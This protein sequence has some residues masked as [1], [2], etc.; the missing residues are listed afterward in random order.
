MTT[1]R[2]TEKQ[3]AIAKRLL[4]S[5]AWEGGHGFRGEAL[6]TWLTMKDVY[7]RF[8]LKVAGGENPRAAW[9]LCSM[10]WVTTRDCLGTLENPGTVGGKR[11]AARVRSLLPE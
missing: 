10:L 6:T 7:L 2:Y 4:A 1:R 11:W 9:W 5:K 8:L 3:R